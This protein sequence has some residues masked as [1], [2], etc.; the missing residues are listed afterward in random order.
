MV[1]M[2]FDPQIH[3]RRSIRLKGYDYTLPGA[4][5]ITIGTWHNEHLFSTVVQGEMRLNRFG[6]IVLQTWDDLPNHYSH[7][8]L[9]VFCVM[10]DHVHGIIV[11]IEARAGGSEGI[12]YEAEMDIPGKAP[13]LASTKTRPCIIESGMLERPRGTD[14][15]SEGESEPAL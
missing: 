5:F 8:A 1:P 14:P 3:H 4:Y 7:V 12:S 13:G 6:Q 9:D 11:L 15:V 10:P 2:K